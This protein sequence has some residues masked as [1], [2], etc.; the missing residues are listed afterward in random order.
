MCSI[1]FIYNNNANAEKLNEEI[2]NMASA[3]KYRGP[4]DTQCVIKDK[5][6]LS[7]NLLDIIGGSQPIHDKTKNLI[8]ICNGEIF[9]HA[10]LK[11]SYFSN[12]KFLTKSD[13][14]I[15]L[16]LYKKMGVNCLKYLEGQFSFLLFDLNAK[17]I[18]IARDRFGINPLFYHKQD[19]VFI[20]SSEIKSILAANIIKNLRLN[21]TAVAQN[22]FFYGALLPH[23]CF[24]D[25]FQLP[26]ASFGIYDIQTE[27][28][29]I[30]PYYNLKTKGSKKNKN[31]LEKELKQILAESVKKRLQG[32]SIPGVYLSGGLDSSIIAYLMSRLS[33]KTKL[34]SIAFKNPQ[35]DESKYQLLLAKTLH[36]KLKQILISISDISDNVSKSIYHAETPL[37]RTAP[38]PMMLLSKMVRNERV[39][40]VL[41][42]EGA[43]ELFA[44]Y[45]V[46]L[47]GKSSFQDKWPVIKNFINI[48][49]DDSIKD[50]ILQEYKKMNKKQ[51]KNYL[52][53]SRKKEISTKLSQYL[54]SNQGDRMSMANGVEQRFPFLDTDV[55]NFAFSLNKK[56]L[57]YK[58]EG[59]LILKQTFKNE[60]PDKIANRKKQGYIA[61]DIEVIKHMLKQKDNIDLLSFTYL[62]KTNIFDYKIVKKLT[63]KVLQ[64][65]IL[66]EFE[67]NALLFILSTQIL[68]KIFIEDKDKLK[69]ALI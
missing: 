4:D 6:A 57:I 40:F 59:K 61:P 7:F 3:T 62:Q 58:K 21:K 67:A 68:Y 41:C 38:I 35:F 22:M 50:N 31:Q 44:G 63:K 53:D 47:K 1:N 20:V 33:K 17:K 46:F 19:G 30:K 66:K 56:H 18:L 12:D 55:V 26:P 5:C 65:N 39:K 64:D 49:N 34:F 45:P 16:H 32:N 15:I 2:Q 42:G 27:T 25:I 37:I 51:S 48:F 23:T 36:L 9:N 24:F 28:I 29:S 10:E 43:D 69:F 13:V 60:I 8:L 14:E 52:V 54:L 11:N